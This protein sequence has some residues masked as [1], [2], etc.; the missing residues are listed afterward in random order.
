MHRYHWPVILTFVFVLILQNHPGFTATLVWDANPETTVTG[1]K[2]HLGTKT[3]NYSSVKNVGNST[4]YNLNLLNRETEYYIAVTAYNNTS[5]SDYS[6]EISYTVTDGIDFEDDN[7]PDIPN[8][9]ELGMCVMDTN[10]IILSCNRVCYND[11]DCNDNEKC[12]LDQEDADNDKIG[13]PC[14][15]HSDFDNNGLVGL[16]D[17]IILKV[18]YIRNDCIDSLCLSD[19][20]MDGQVS[21]ME[22]TRLAIEYGTVCPTPIP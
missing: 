3:R 7:C 15:C 12:Q 9:P 1:Y 18:E 20:D 4:Q 22:L 10:G 19:I 5:E 14:E 17:F 8:G 2:V 21:F 16:S 6:E 13:D 11:S